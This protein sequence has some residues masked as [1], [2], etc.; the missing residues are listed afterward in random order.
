MEA[1]VG[2]VE[3]LFA[4]R[5]GS[6]RINLLPALVP[7]RS[8]GGRGQFGWRRALP[9]PEEKGSTVWLAFGSALAKARRW[10]V[11]TASL[12][13][14]TAGGRAMQPVSRAPLQRQRRQCS[15]PP[16]LL[17][18]PADSRRLCSTCH[19]MVCNFAFV[20]AS[21]SNGHPHIVWMLSASC[22]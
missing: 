18:M 4:A 21:T 9:P 22:V 2:L 13:A 17:Y 8:I 15:L 14:L 5:G 12:P 10:Q 6:A 7:S 16:H 3:A 11:V 20:D 1:R 19:Q